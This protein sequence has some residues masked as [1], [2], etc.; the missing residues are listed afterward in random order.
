MR[1]LAL[2][3]SLIALGPARAQLFDSIAHFAAE[4]PRFVAKVDLRGSFISNHSARVAG[5]KVGLEHARRF[6]YGIGYHFLLSPVRRWTA[7]DDGREVEL[8]LRLGYVAPYVDH[9]FYQRGPWEVRIPVQVGIGRGS[10]V[11]RDANGRRQ[12]H[13][14]TALVV[15]EPAMTVQYRFMRY[16]GAGAGWGFRLVWQTDGPLGEALTAP[17]YTFGL[18]VFFGELWRDV[19]GG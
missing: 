14:R 16:L 1:A 3:L 13:R 7:L 9:A 2:V 15:Y 4:R 12:V 8:G 11:Y 18:R 19:R 6:Q 5:V 10:Q 17:I